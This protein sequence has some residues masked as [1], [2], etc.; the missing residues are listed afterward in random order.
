LGVGAAAR[1]TRFLPGWWI[2]PGLVMSATGWA[3][4]IW[5][6]LTR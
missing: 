2:L 1:S 4:V 5:L 3:T 6:L